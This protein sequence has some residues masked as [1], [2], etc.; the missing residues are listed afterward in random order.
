M[1]KLF[2]FLLI[3][4]FF[5]SSQ[6]SSKKIRVLFIGNSYTYVNNL[7]QLAASIALSKGDTMIFDSYCPGGYTF[8]NH[9]NDANT[10]AKIALGNWNYVVLQAQSQEPSFS[11]TQVSAQTLPYAIKLDSLIKHYNPCANTVF[12]ETWGRKFGDA[13][14]C[15]AYPPVCTYTGMQNRLRAS[16]KLFADT[17]HD[18][19]APV[20]EAFRQV[21]ATNTLIDLYQADQSHPSL[22]GSYLAASVF[23]ETLFQK[24]VL[25]STY[26]PGLAT[27]TVSYFKQV[28]HDLV[29]D[30]AFTWNISK[31][32]PKATLTITPVSASVYQ[33]QSGATPFLKKWYFGDGNTSITSNPTH[34]YSAPGNYTASLVVYDNL[35]CKKDSVTSSVTIPVLTGL[36][37]QNGRTALSVY[38]NP[39]SGDLF[40][41]AGNAFEPSSSF[42]EI[43]NVLGQNV[44]TS[45]FSERINISALPQ[46]VYYIRLFH[47]L[48]EANS[49]FIKN[50]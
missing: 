32:I 9:V 12:Y 46:G 28:A 21:V 20:G 10:L 19:M 44:Y 11:P 6:T 23:Y 43:V 3:L 35:S 42:I 30:S 25:T 13:M 18:L 5:L 16:Y 49:C 47:D 4:P 34:T 1:K 31:Y 40:I 41:K 14:N 15:A 17:V 45:A 33:F 27:A 36:L 50:E 7:P 39:T 26:N 24:S 38:P 8:N 22:E 2:C 29:N 37:A 48:E